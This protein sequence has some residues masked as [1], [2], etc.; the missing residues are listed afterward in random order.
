MARLYDALPPALRGA[1]A[2]NSEALVPL[3]RAAVRT[4]DVVVVKG[5]LGSRMGRVV[6]ALLGGTAN[7]NG[8][9][10]PSGRAANG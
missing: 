4:G 9:N 2:P 5:S 8:R 10:G 3:I 7:S 1:H 6:D